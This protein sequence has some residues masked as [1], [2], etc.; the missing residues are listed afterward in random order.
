MGQMMVELMAKTIRQTTDVMMAMPT[1]VTM[2][3]MVV[4]P[5]TVM[6]DP[7]TAVYDNDHTKG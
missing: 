4:E 6:T 5:L 7:T 2:N 1:A 3:P